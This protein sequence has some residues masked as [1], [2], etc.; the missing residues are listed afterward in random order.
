MKPYL[1]LLATM[2]TQ[3]AEPPRFLPASECAMC[4]RQIPEPGQPWGSTPSI[5]Q[6]PLWS[7]SMMAHSSVDPYWRARVRTEIA[8]QPTRQAE[9]EAT[10]LRCH[11]PMQPGTP[12]ASLSDLGND[13]V[14]CTLCHQIQPANL[15]QTSSFTGGF[16]IGTGN[17]LFGPHAD[18]FSMPM[19]HH[20]GFEPRQAR[21]IMDSALCGTCHTVI[22]EPPE[23]TAAAPFRFVEQ[24]PFLEWLASSFPASG[25]T[26][27]SCH[28]LRLAT[29]QYIAHRPPGGAFPPTDPRTPFGRHEFVGGNT[30]IPTMLGLPETARRAQAQLERSL[31]LEVITQRKE[32]ALLID[33]TVHNR[34]GH[35]LPTGF[36]SRRLWLRVALVDQQ[37]K[38]LWQSGDWDPATGRL[39]AGEASQP[40][41]TIIDK[42]DQVQIF[43]VESQDAARRPIVAL[44]RSAYIAKDNR[45]LPAGF[46]PAH[47]GGYDIRPVGAEIHPGSTTTRYHLPAT[48]TR[49]VVEALYQS[50]KP[51]HRPADFPVATPVVVARV[52]RT[53]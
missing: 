40:H 5:G 7:G 47:A 25:Q 43:E 46:D 52:D 26:C 9:I 11:A 30:V 49:L 45:V 14:S 29:P 20:S 1:L 44:L 42:P 17:V 15:G 24:A 22:T 32:R 34:T 21:H 8:S 35:K 37:G 23:S 4:H 19:L 10:C 18:P 50:I 38:T 3:G 2:M 31:S 27:Q 33:V 13:G 6:H 16:R 36:P 51:T 12:L 28:M 53:L 41:H 48:G 39:I